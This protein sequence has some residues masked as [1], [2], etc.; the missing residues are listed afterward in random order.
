M[1]KNITELI[2]EADKQYKPFPNF[3]D[4]LQVKVFY[5]IFGR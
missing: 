4:W 5:A 2:E 3:K 1:D